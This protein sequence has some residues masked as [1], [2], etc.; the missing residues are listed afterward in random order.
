MITTFVFDMF[1]DESAILTY[2]TQ[3][4]ILW[5][6]GFGPMFERRTFEYIDQDYGPKQNLERCPVVKPEESDEKQPPE[7]K[8]E[9]SG[10]KQP[11]EQKS[12]L[13]YEWVLVKPEVNPNQ[14]RESY[15]GGGSTPYWFTEAR[16]EGKSVTYTATD[17]SFAIHDVDVDHGYTYRDVTIQVDFDAPP[18]IL[19]QGA[20]EE[21]SVHFS[22]SGSV[23]EGG[24]GIFV[25]FW[26]SSDDVSIDPVD[27]YSYA[28]WREDFDGSRATEYILNV[29][30]GN[31]GDEFTLYASLMNA[32]P[33][34]V[35]W[36]YRLQEA[37]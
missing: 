10:E 37:R 11:Q 13:N 35:V 8:P 14:A 20:R 5:M 24:T 33:C 21:L 7:L 28:P 34:L 29:P 32:E 12:E 4:P 31:V 18:L 1:C 2:G 15:T 26:Y 9:E 6:N 27:F 22:H 3:D 23:N 25:Q 16:F 19:E 17:S 36:T 30:H